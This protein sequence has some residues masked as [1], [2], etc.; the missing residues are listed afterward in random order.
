MVVV[1]AASAV[2]TVV[3]A[4]LVDDDAVDAAADVDEVDASSR[5]I[6]E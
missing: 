4:S 2:A 1:E 3:D 5:S 6:S